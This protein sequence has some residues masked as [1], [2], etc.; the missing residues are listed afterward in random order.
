MYPYIKMQSGVYEYVRVHRTD[1]SS[2]STVLK[3]TQ[4]FR[5][6]HLVFY[7]WEVLILRTECINSVLEHLFNQLFLVI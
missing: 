3:N 4:A 5:V 2:Q 7:L 1:T 6:I